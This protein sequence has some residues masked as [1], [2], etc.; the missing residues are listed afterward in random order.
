[1]TALCFAALAAESPTARTGELIYQTYCFS[2]HGTG[3]Q[4]APIAFD[5]HEWA[6]RVA[7]GLNGLLASAKQGVNSMPP[8]GTCMDCTDAELTAAIKEMTKF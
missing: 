1:M 5:E 2:C 3:W 7:K 4:G 8:M 6:P